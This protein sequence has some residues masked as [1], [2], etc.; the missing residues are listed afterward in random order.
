MAVSINKR[1]SRAEEPDI[2]GGG[3]RLT[4]SAGAV[5]T[6]VACVLLACATH[7]AEVPRS[8]T[9]AV[10]QLDIPSQPIGD[11]LSRL[12]EVAGVQIVFYSDVTSGVRAQRLTGQYTLRAALDLMLAGSALE[13]EFLS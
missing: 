13:Y 10:L 2:V 8:A 5:A 6:A 12:A 1:F 3:G 4:A 11:A 9:A 7:G